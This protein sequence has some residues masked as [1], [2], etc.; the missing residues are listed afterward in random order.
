MPRLAPVTNA[1][2]PSIFISLPPWWALSAPFA[3][4]MMVIIWMTCDIL[5][6][7]M[8]S[9]IYTSS[10]GHSQSE[11]EKNHQRIVEI[12]ARKIRESGIDGPGVAE[13]M[14]EAGLTHGGFYKHFDSRDD[15]IA[16]AVDAAIEQGQSDLNRAVEGAADPLAA[17]LEEYVSEKHRDAPGT[18]CTVVALG[19][20]AARSDPRVRASYGAQVENYITHMEGLL[21]GGEDAR[22]KAIAAVTSMVG[23]VL[24][25]RA[26]D[27]ADL[28]DEILAEVRAEVPN[29]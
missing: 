16:D 29:L 10:M 1:V 19:A 21:G 15:L 8:M 23:A 22:R 12:A 25:S 9:I 18:G 4:W 7:K 11:K 28:S 3:V 26:I 5:T 13:V 24:I 20:D 14:K 27:D 2:A 6:D 17:F